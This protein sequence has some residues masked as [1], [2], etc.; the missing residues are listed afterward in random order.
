MTYK[1]GSSL[2]YCL[3]DFNACLFISTFLI[4][5]I[6]ASFFYISQKCNNYRTRA[7]ISHGF[8]NFYPIFLFGLYCRAASTTDNLCTK[9]G[10][11]S[12]A[13]SKIRGLHSKVGYNSN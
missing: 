9:K 7:I 2:M 11:S 12:I 10:N 13:G 1:L 5:K 6:D 8:H 4:F 3:G